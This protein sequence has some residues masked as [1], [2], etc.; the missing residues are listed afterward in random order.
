MSIRI[1]FY[2]I[3]LLLCGL[4]AWAA[5]HAAADAT[6]IS[7]Q[8]YP[9]EALLATG[10]ERCEGADADLVRAWVRA[11][12]RKSGALAS[13][14]AY[15]SPAG[16]LSV[17]A[18]APRGQAPRA[19]ARYRYASLTK[20]LT[21]QA[22]VEAMGEAGLP[23][24]TP[25]AHFV[26]QAG[27]ADDARWRRVTIAQLLAH[28]A[29]LDRRRSPD[30]L[31]VHAAQPWCPG[32]LERLSRVRLDF[33]PGSRHA[34]SNL[35]YCLLGVVLERLDGVPFRAALQ[36][37]F[38]LAAYGIRF[39]DGP[40][41]P[42][43]VAYDFRHAGFYGADY[44]RYLDFPA[45]S[46]SAG[47]SGTA[48]ALVRLLGTLRAEGR[49]SVAKAPIPADCDPAVKHS[50][51]G[52]ALFPYRKRGQDLL[53]QVQQGYLF[54]VSTVAV[55]DARGGISVWLGNGSPAHGRD[56]SDEM[57]DFIYDGL[58]TRFAQ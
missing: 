23:L 42:D 54:G 10:N 13:E 21:A 41:L 58:V 2:P 47:L 37:R 17:C 32:R 48:G 12:R 35:G 3:V 52:Q 20:L 4:G 27:H 49:L 6:W 11:A 14:A 33:A 25:L 29:G 43:E 40:Y 22:V 44:Y 28:S 46:S 34:Y 15:L 50:C 24:A 7:R 26:A 57:L 36:R 30:P 19:T 53:V 18:S 1:V 39:I 55:L 56:G 45:L 16:N 38:D 9:L 31:T 5:H 8:L 51:F